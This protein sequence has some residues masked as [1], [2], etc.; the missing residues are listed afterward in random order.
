[1]PDPVI[2]FEVIGIDVVALQAFYAK[3]FGW[4]IDA[5][6]PLR[7]GTVEAAPG[8]IAGGV[9]PS[10]DG[11]SRAMFYV[12]VADLQVTL[13]AAEALGATTVMPPVE[14]RG[15]RRIAMFNDPEDNCVGLMQQ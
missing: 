3:V 13:D 9:V 5:D 1:M 11:T 15:G 2:H 8:G 4:R 7:Y 12:A 14:I 10:V 6:N